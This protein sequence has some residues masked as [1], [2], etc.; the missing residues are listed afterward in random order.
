MEVIKGQ[1]GE[2]KRLGTSDPVNTTNGPIEV[3]GT[4]Y[5]EDT[6]KFFK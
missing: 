4:N 1:S 3:K 2:R 6:Q 5:R